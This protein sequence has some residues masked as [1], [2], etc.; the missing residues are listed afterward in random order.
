LWPLAAGCTIARARIQ[1]KLS[2]DRRRVSAV[3]AGCIALLIGL[4]GA[5]YG[6]TKPTFTNAHLFDG[7]KY[8]GFDTAHPG[9]AVDHLGVVHLRG[10]L[11]GGTEGS[12]AFV[13][14]SALAPSHEI[15][16]PIEVGP[17]EGSALMISTTGQVIP[18]GPATSYYLPLDEVNF[19]ARTASSIKFTDAKLLSG[20]RYGGDN[21]AWPGYALDSLGVVHLRGGLFDG[22][23]GRP[24]FVLPQALRPSE[25][26]R[27][28]IY[29]SGFTAGSLT[30]G[31]N[32]HATPSGAA[33]AGYASLDGITFAAGSAGKIRFT[34]AKLT[35]R[36]TYAG[37]GSARPG[38]SKDSWAS[39]T[40]AAPCG[41][42]GA[43]RSPS[44]C[45][46]AYARATG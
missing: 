11:K 10:S 23:S 14:P 27:V 45:P 40:C 34:N 35:Q 38:F 43:T 37:P 32:G 25:P 30:V 33:V 42:G 31:T 12:E 41:T 19:V 29:T 8:G 16:L 44:R 7:W 3:V 13:L 26:I 5:T 2:T 4:A 39:F 22:T 18:D 17:G 46:R 9:Y 6:A 28:P 15:W 36:W 20:W 21:S 1:V 24:A